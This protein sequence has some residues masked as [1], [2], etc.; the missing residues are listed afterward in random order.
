M[1]FEDAQRAYD[2][3]EEPGEDDDLKCTEC[4]QFPCRCV[5]MDDLIGGIR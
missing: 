4:G 3:E 5:E 2:N 1:T